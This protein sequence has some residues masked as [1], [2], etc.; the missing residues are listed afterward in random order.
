MSKPK[1]DPKAVNL[2]GTQ[3]DSHSIPCE[4][5]GSK[6]WPDWVLLPHELFNQICPSGNGYLCL[7]CFSKR[8]LQSRLNQKG[9]ATG[10]GE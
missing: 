7:S 4:D 1:N 8:V 5:C 6:D 9:R 3:K 10:G 2:G